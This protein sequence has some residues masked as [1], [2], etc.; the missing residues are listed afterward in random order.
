MMIGFIAAAAFNVVDTFYVSRL[1]TEALAAMGY[2]FPIVMTVFAMAMGIGVGTASVLSRTIGQGNHDEVKRITVDALLLGLGLALIFVVAGLLALR[3]LLQALGAKGTT[4]SLA[5]DYMRIWYPGVLFVI[6]PM[7]GNHAIRATGDMLSPSIIMTV[8]VGLNALLDP[9]LIFGWGPIASMG[10]KGA[11]LATVICRALG[12]IASLYILQH[13]KQ[14]LDWIRPQ[15]QQVLD[16][17]KRI[18]YIALPTTGANLLMPIAMGVLTRTVSSLGTSRVAAFS[19]G[20]RIERCAVIPLA[21]MGVSV[22]PLVGQNWGNGLYGRVRLALRTAWL[23]CLAWG[24]VCAIGLAVLAAFFAGIFTQE[25]AVSMS[26]KTFL[27]ILP[28]AFAF[29]GILHSTTGALNAINRPLDSGLISA[30]RLLALQLPLAI[31]GAHFFDFPGLLWGIV[32]AEA[33]ATLIAISRLIYLLP[34]QLA[35][36]GQVD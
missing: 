34:R 19:V 17:W 10:V 5:M 4:L 24:A 9:I 33:L 36:I 20:M 15:L 28:L 26:L 16:S 11:A 35:A 30:L 25:P 12:L 32:V 22:I 29:R 13:K 3:P 23:T 6:V 21:A 27:Y 14:M 2:T 18:L 7:V 8:N 31:L 1:G